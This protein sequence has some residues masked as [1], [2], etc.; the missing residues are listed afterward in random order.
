MILASGSPRRREL[1][2]ELGFSPTIRPADIDEA[3]RPGED[4]QA[5]VRRLA[6]DKAMAC[7]ESMPRLPQEA[8]V[9]A[10][11]IVWTGNTV[12]GKPADAD[13]ARRM[14]KSLSGKTHSVSTGVCIIA[15]QHVR[16]PHAFVETSAVTFFKLTDE[17]I[18][19]YVASEEPLDKAG[20][21]GI[22][23][24]GRLLVS[25]IEG[26]YFTIVGLPVA[27]L[28]RELER[29]GCADTARVLGGR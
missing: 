2:E 24:A 4:P 29:L 20:A 6:R 16:T 14:L 3:R 18:D 7:L 9:A 8:I 15:P 22:Q 17:Q 12:L 21:Y 5:L 27:R 28:V 10:D 13:D 26:D 23:G 25:G 11:T 1:L 19:A